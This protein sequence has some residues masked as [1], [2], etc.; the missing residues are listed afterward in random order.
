MH[1]KRVFNEGWMCQFLKLDVPNLQIFINCMIQMK[2]DITIKRK[3]Y[4]MVHEKGV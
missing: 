1:I 3:G 2:L 4:Q